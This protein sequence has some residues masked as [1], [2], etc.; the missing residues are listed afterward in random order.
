[1]DAALRLW[2]AEVGE[3]A[4]PGST[5][6]EQDVVGLF[7]EFRAPLLRYLLSLGVPVQDGEE[8]IQETFLALFRHL[9]AGKDRRNLRGW[10]FRV[11]HNLGLKRRHLNQRDLAGWDLAG[12]TEAEEAQAVLA[13]PAPGPEAQCVLAERRRAMEAVMA[14]L[15]ERERQCLLLRAEGLRYREIARVLDISL[16]AVALHLQ[17]SLDRL[18]RAMERE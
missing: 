8:I 13:D 11:A 5:R 10:L 6:L 3:A 2:T 1:L 18:G 7:D 9:R 17:R 15:S 4:M 14:A 12:R 16:G